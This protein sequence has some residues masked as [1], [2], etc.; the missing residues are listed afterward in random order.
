M[1]GLSQLFSLSLYGTNITNQGVKLLG[2][3]PALGSIDLGSTLVTDQGLADL[4]GL[5]QLMRLRLDQMSYSPDMPVRVTDAGLR[6]IAKMKK[7]E[8]PG[9]GQFALYG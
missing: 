7:L 9:A 6:E 5:P 3:N 1:V 2:K 8:S 4:V